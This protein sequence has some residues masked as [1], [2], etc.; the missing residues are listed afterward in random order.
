MKATVNPIELSKELKKMSSIVKK[1]HI[2]PITSAVLF[3]FSKDKITVTG[4][5]LETTYIISL[6]CVCKEE[7]S[8]PIDYFDVSEICSNC[9][10]PLTIEL[11]E[12]EI[13]LST[14]KPYKTKL[15]RI[16]NSNEFP[17]VPEDEYTHEKEVE[18]EF[19]YYLNNANSCRSKEELRANLNMA[20]IMVT[21]QEMS[22]AGSDAMILY[23]KTFKEKCDFE[24]TVMVSD[25]FVSL[26]KNFQQSKMIFGE[27]YIKVERDSETVISRLSENKFANINAIIPTEVNYN[28]ELQKNELSMALKEISVSSDITTK[29]FLLNFKKGKINLVSQNLDFNKQSETTITSDHSVEIDQ[30]CLKSSHLLH[31]TSITDT[32]TISFAVTSHN[33]SVFMQ[34]KGDD[35]IVMLLFPL[36]IQ[37]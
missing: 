20:A 24:L 25:S 27:K 5:D 28:M 15:P 26:C 6:K 19:F 3:S 17:L 37:N 14:D 1:N 13:I 30:L 18:G 29:Q 34:P 7:F 22:V 31:L 8:F 23:K 21:K 33:K 11:K 16:G 10:I 35:S 9:F 36:M 2:V 12:N 32:E 4:T